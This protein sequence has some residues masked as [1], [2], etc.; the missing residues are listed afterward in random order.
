MTN[1]DLDQVEVVEMNVDELSE[2]D[3][4]VIPLILIGVGWGVMLT[5]SAIALALQHKYDL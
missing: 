3:G 5:C 2:L 1:F 4:G